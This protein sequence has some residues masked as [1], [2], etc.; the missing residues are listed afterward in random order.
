LKSLGEFLNKLE[1]VKKLGNGG[2]QSLC[3]AHA[4]TKP[5]LSITQSKDRILINCKEMV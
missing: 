1:K 2:F 4:D 3:P 5:S